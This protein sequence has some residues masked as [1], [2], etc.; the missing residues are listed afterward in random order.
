MSTG[1]ITLDA[2]RHFIKLNSAACRILRASEADFLERD[3][4]DVFSGGNAWINDSL[5]KVMQSGE[6]D[7]S[8]DTRAEIRW[9]AGHVDQ[10]ERGAVLDVR[11][12]SI[13]FMLIIEDISSE[14]RVR[15]TMARYMTKEVA[16][17]LLGRRRIGPRRRGAGSHH[18]VF[19]H[20]QFH[21]HRRGNRRAG[22][23]VHVE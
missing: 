23:S 11:N 2:K 17:R 7:L 21:Q 20:S 10:P 12:E 1:V 6:A 5:D 4:R 14:K 3:A 15:G 9:R 18:S 8:M 19:G 13:G 16:D 22:N